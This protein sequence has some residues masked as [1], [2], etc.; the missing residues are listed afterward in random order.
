MESRYQ[1]DMLSVQY[2]MCVRERDNL[3]HE[4]ES[5]RW[6]AQA[7][8]VIERSERESVGRGYLDE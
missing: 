1:Q 8:S 4:N 2:L 5:P 7:F 3:D 6:E